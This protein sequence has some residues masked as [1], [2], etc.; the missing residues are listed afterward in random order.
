MYS[1]DFPGLILWPSKVDIF[2]NEMHVFWIKTA[3]ILVVIEFAL[4][5]VKK[6]F[7]MKMIMDNNHF[8][9]YK[10]DHW[11]GYCAN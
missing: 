9:L 10:C 6:N 11:M 7:I 4:T 2:E 3:L 5:H 8:K 1:W